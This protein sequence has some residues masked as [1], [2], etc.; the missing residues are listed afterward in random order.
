M[1]FSMP[2]PK[3][4]RKQQRVV[5]IQSGRVG[6]ITRV[7]RRLIVVDYPNMFE[8]MTGQIGYHRPTV[9]DHLVH[10]D[11]NAVTNA[12]LARQ[13]AAEGACEVA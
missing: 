13:K 12:E 2:K 10:Y 1:W 8:W 7:T 11:P 4:F 3:A 5:D 9:H 6:S